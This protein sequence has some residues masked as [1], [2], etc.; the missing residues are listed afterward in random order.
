MAS[1]V[2][3]E[4]NILHSH[5]CVS[6]LW[7]GMAHAA[8]A[9]SVFLASHPSTALRT[10]EQIGGAN[11]GLNTI[12]DLLLARFVVVLSSVRDDERHTQIGVRVLMTSSISVIATSSLYS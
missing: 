1:N 10:A 5:S 7:R 12:V 4:H 2:E 8:E 9:E 11:V 6:C 3:V